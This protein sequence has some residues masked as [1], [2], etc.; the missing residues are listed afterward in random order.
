MSAMNPDRWGEVEK[1]YR[2][3]LKREPAERMPFLGGP[4]VDVPVFLPI[5][6]VVDRR[7]ARSGGG[8]SAKL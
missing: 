5:A 3:A 4:I 7:S 2:A 8:R 1:L 6:Y